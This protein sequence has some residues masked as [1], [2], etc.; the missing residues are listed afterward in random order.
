M[1]VDHTWLHRNLEQSWRLRTC[2][3]IK[4][5]TLSLI[6]DISTWVLS[7]LGRATFTRTLPTFRAV[8]LPSTWTTESWDLTNQSTESYLDCHVSTNHVSAAGSS[9]RGSINTATVMVDSDGG[10]DSLISWNSQVTCSYLERLSSSVIIGLEEDLHNIIIVPHV[11]LQPRILS[12][13]SLTNLINKQAHM[14]SSAR[15]I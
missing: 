12:M 2:S 13:I 1:L 9:C 5:S 15:C 11:K 4:L 6:V 10:V 8:M 14:I 3:G 7:Q